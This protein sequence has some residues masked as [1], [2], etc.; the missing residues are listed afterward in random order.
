MT[1]TY[2]EAIATAGKALIT[3]IALHDSIGVQV[4]DGRKAVTWGANN[5]NGDFFMSTDLIFDMSA[6]QEVAGWSGWSAATG[7]TRYGGADLSPRSFV[8]PG[9]YTLL[10]NHTGIKH[11]AWNA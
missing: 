5:G 4:G 8:N 3:H 1:N 2:L 7:G 6:G 10:A 9:T 11:N